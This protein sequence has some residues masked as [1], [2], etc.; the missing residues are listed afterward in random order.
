MG[1]AP[2]CG[3]LPLKKCPCYDFAEGKTILLAAVTQILS[4]LTSCRL[5]IFKR[6]LLIPES[7]IM[8]SNLLLLSYFVVFEISS[9]FVHI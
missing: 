7:S 1:S 2:F 5:T 4:C 8:C 3:C 9:I 6:V